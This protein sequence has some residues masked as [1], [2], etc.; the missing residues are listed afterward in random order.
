MALRFVDSGVGISGNGEYPP[1]NPGV[2]Y[3]T[4]TPGQ[5]QWDNGVNPPFYVD[6]LIVEPSS[7]FL[8]AP[9]PP[10]GYA[11]T[12]FPQEQGSLIGDGNDYMFAAASGYKVGSLSTGFT[13]YNSPRQA[14]SIS[15]FSLFHY[16]SATLPMVTI[17]THQDGGGP[18]DQATAGC[19]GT[20]TVVVTWPQTLTLPGGGALNFNS[21]PTLTPSGGVCGAGGYTFAITA[22]A[23]PNGLALNTGT[24]AIT[25]TPTIAANGFY[26][27]TVGAQKTSGS[28]YCWGSVD[29]AGY[30]WTADGGVLVG[31]SAVGP[32]YINAVRQWEIHRMDIKRR[33]EQTS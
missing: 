13:A 1:V 12:M 30:V 28:S 6:Q 5:I 27:F 29:F 11:F 15:D 21:L 20:C 25:G 33:K 24:G 8:V 31:G 10:C 4:L 18:I 7:G 17:G 9:A 2:S 26:S 16:G 23:L 32:I 14:L 19:L 3:F 22:G